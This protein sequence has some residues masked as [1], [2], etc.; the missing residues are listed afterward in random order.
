MSTNPDWLVWKF[1]D[2]NLHTLRETAPFRGVGVTEGRLPGTWR[3]A[4]ST[5]SPA[6]GGSFHVY[7]SLVKRI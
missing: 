7:P 2:K 3:E 6:T 1:F 4:Q 5:G